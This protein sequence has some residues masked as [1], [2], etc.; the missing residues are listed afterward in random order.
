MAEL[1]DV[2]N[3]MF[4]K[5]EWNK[6]SD[7]DKER[8]FFIFNRYFA[9]KYP[10]RSQLLNLKV[11]DKVSSLDLW[12]HFM[13]DK[14]YPNWFWSKSGKTEKSEIPEK[15]YKLLLMKLKIKDIDLDYIIENNPEFIKEE[16]KYY[17]D[18]DKNNK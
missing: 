17:K 15:D 2:A 10:E 13:K 9:K 3:A 12:Y 4:H 16:L 11:I 7:F 6:I 18:L 1:I 8:F 14:P 5:A